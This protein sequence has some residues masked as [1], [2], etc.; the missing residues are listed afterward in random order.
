MRALISRD[1]GVGAN[2][3]PVDQ[4]TGEIGSWSHFSQ[5]WSGLGISR[6]I[7][8]APRVEIR[9]YARAS[10]VAVFSGNRNEDHP[11]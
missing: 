10:E 2:D 9:F 5:Y 11:G 1:G 8:D 6:L 4:F 7:Y 3:F